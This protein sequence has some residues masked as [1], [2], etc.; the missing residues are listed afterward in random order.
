MPVLVK[1]IKLNFTIFLFNVAYKPFR[2]VRFAH[3]AQQD[4]I[5]FVENY[6]KHHSFIQTE[7]TSVTIVLACQVCA[8]MCNEHYTVKMF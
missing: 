1:W 8:R 4:Q 5:N 2:I 3:E 7:K 6:N